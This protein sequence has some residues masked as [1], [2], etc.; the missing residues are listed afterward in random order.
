[1]ETTQTRAAQQAN[2]KS[3]IILPVIALFLICIITALALGMTNQATSPVIASNNAK[4]ADQERKKL[5]P[6]ANAF[7]EIAA[8]QGVDKINSVYQA[9]NG[10]GMVIESYEQG[11]SGAVPA[12]VA[13]D[14]SGKVAGVTFLSNTETVGLGQKVRD[15]SF[16]AQFAKRSSNEIALSD[17]DTITSATISSKAAMNAVNHAIAAYQALQGGK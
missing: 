14:K 13:F 15:K 5:L 1:M 7:K 8:P 16:S 11:Y 17:I 6:N 2:I 3:E 9:E 4:V 12:M 10:V